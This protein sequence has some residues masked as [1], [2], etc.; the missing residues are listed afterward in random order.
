MPEQVKQEHLDRLCPELA[1]LLRAELA[2]GNRV[3]DTSEGWPQA[4]S[5]FVGLALPFRHRPTSLPPGVVYR[6]VN[7]AHWWKA[8]YEHEPSGHLLTCKFR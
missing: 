1:E 3:V 5:V 8:E 4:A 7:D 2:A 6:D